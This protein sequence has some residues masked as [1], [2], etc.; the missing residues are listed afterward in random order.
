MNLGRLL[1]AS[2][3][4]ISVQ[5]LQKVYSGDKGVPALDGLDFVIDPGEVIVVIGSKGAGKSTLITVLSGAMDP[6]EGSF[7]V[8]GITSSFRNIQQ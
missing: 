5:G 6:T 3:R 1:H 8:T 7:S 4:M 2:S